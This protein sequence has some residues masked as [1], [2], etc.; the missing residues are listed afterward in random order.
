MLPTQS[1]VVEYVRE[2]PGCLSRDVAK[3]FKCKSAD[4][5][6]ARDG[7]CGIYKIPGLTHDNF[8]H[9]V[10]PDVT[11]SVPDVVTPQSNEESVPDVVTPQS[12]EENAPDVVEPAPR[13]I[14]ARV[15]PA[16]TELV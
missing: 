14:R 9:T 8:R 7:Y 3:H 6:R 15:K 12:D 1:Q 5:N 11:E 10:V 4:I 13:R 2:H 16:P